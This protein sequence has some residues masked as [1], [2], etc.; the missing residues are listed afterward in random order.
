MHQQ[1]SA[2]TLVKPVIPAWRGMPCA[3]TARPRAPAHRKPCCKALDRILANT[4]KLPLE[5]LSK[6]FITAFMGALSHPGGKRYPD[7]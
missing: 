4:G 5:A 3:T 6:N 1:P 7:L 2:T